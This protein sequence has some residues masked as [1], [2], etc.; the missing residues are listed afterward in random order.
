M[1][2]NHSATLGNCQGPPR[3]GAEDGRSDECQ[4][5]PHPSVCHLRRS[6]TN[7]LVMQISFSWSTRTGGT[8]L[9]PEEPRSDS[10]GAS[11]RCA[12]IQA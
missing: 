12:A 6:A 8:N 4:P 2:Q 1:D 5:D 7:L 10:S 9:A 3:R 11:L